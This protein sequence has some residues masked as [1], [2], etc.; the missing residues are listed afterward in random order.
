MKVLL[1]QFWDTWALQERVIIA[2]VAALM[3]VALYLWLVHAAD[4]ARRQLRSVVTSLH[5]E[6][7]RLDQNAAEIERLRA[8]RATPAS[9]TELRTLVQAQAAAL[10]LSRAL[11][12]IDAPDPNQVRVAFG[13]VPF[14]DWL[15]WVIT[16]Q[17]QRIR[18]DACRIEALSTPGIVS[19]TAT[20]VRAEQ[21]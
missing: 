7:S 5:A 17:S 15:A 12:R 16:L 11:V 6:A 2:V 18:L 10:G 13:A 8:A 20:L 14:T 9:R 19:A 3:G 1:R 21:Q 4:G